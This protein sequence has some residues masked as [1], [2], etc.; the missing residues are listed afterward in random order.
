M[1]QQHKLPRTY[2]WIVVNPP[3]LS[4]SKMGGESLMMDGVYDE[5]HMLRHSFALASTFLDI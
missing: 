3:W 1:V 5:S 2:Q 4:S